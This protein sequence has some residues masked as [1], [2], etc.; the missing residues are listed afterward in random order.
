VSSGRTA[1]KSVIWFRGH[2]ADPADILEEAQHAP[3]VVP[4]NTVS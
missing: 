4:E 2:S 3:S 1:T